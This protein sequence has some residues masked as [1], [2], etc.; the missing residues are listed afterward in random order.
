MLVSVCSAHG[1]KIDSENEFF[2]DDPK[3]T[4]DQKN[5]F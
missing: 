5:A 3:H 4:R 2:N 1:T